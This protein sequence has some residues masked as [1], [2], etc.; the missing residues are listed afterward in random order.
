MDLVIDVFDE[1]FLKILI[2]EIVIMIY[3]SNI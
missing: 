3:E 2:L 1:G